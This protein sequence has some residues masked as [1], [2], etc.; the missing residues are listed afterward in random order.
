[1]VVVKILNRKKD[2]FL[3]SYSGDIKQ[4]LLDKSIGIDETN[5]G[6]VFLMLTGKLDSP[7]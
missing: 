2:K 3:K 7:L 6:T 4:I 5:D 1:M